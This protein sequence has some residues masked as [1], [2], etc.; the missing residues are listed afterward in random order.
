MGSKLVVMC[1]FWRQEGG[2]TAYQAHHVNTWA[3]MVRRHLT[4]PHELACVTDTPEGIDPSIRII[5]PPRDFENVV[6]PT[7]KGDKPQC[8]RRIALFRPDAAD[9]FGERFVSMDIDCVIGGSLDPLFG[10]HDDF[11]MYSGTTRQR[12]YNGSMLMMT[13]GARPHVYT[14]FTPERAVEAGRKYVGSDQAWISY[15]L[16]WGEAIW[17][18][19]DGVYWW[20]QAG[21]TAPRRLMF[22][23]GH[24]KPWNVVDSGADPWIAEHYRRSPQGRCLILGYAP[25]VWDEASDALD[26]HE[27]NA[28]IASPEAAKHWPGQILA[29]ANDDEHAERLARSLGYDDFV[30][31][32]R[33]A[34]MEAA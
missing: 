7:W 34:K 15:R 31:C 28:V 11:V 24:P 19:A 33:S 21:G 8:L 25:T 20:N 4:L 2:R 30:F 14:D 22:F 6:I 26:D 23:P 3:D 9:I 13:A 10:R 12:P 18:I 32:G 29:V 1:W 27:F 17:S 5:P 16:G